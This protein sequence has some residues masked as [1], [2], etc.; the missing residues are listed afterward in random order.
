[1]L[2][3]DVRRAA[4]LAALEGAI[5]ALLRDAQDEGVDQ[6]SIDVTADCGMVSID[7]SYCSKG[8]PV[9]GQSL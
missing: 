9:A 6:I 4:K 3:H 1:M 7:L 5:L 2:T 8:L